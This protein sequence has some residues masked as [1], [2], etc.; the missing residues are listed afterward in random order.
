MKIKVLIIIDIKDWAFEVIANQISSLNN[1]PNYSFF[2]KT[3]RNDKEKIKK[4]WEEYDIIF[5][6]EW[7]LYEKCSFIPQEKI[8]TGIHC[9]RK[10]DHHLSNGLKTINP[11]KSLIDFLKKFLRINV[12]SLRLYN[13]F[14]KEL[15]VYYTPNG[16]DCNSF[17]PL[18]NYTEEFTVGTVAKKRRFFSKGVDNFIIPAVEKSKVKIKIAD[19]MKNKINY[20]DMPDFYNKLSCY[21][22]AARSEGF[23]LSIL[24]AGSCGIP[25]IST[26]VSGTEELIK[27]GETGLFVERDIN[28]ISEKIDILKRDR[29]YCRYLGKN[30]R[31]YIEKNYSWEK[32]IDKWL[33]F[34]KISQS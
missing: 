11:Q 19:G 26:N 27:N 5:L 25:L 8:I 9:F 16:V 6:M 24:E 18:Y 15:D 1:D 31:K 28:D 2:I 21:I 22:C 14:S 13:V 3:L 20:K 30:V 34:V 17:Y 23:S 10:W 29:E 32:V 33:N 4:T 7:C 12:V